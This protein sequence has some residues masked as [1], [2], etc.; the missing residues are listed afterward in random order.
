MKSSPEKV[1]GHTKEEIIEQA[2]VF[3][4]AWSLVGGPFDCGDCLESAEQEKTHLKG[5]VAKLC[6][7]RDELVKVLRSARNYLDEQFP[8]VDASELLDEEID[9]ILSRYPEKQLIRDHTEIKPT[10]ELV[11]PWDGYPENK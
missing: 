8:M 5:M 9:P 10:G 3:A 11:K 7:E 2:Q 6:A 1:M 4:S